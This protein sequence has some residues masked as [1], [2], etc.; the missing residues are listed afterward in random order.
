MLFRNVDRFGQF[1][2][3][4]LNEVAPGS[5][6]RIKTTM[7]AGKLDIPLPGQ[8]N[9]QGFRQIGNRFEVRK[10]TLVN[11]LV[12]LRRPI[13][14]RDCVSLVIEKEFHGTAVDYFEALSSNSWPSQF[15]SWVTICGF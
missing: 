12:D 6:D 1:A 11:S 5:V 4:K 13:V 3:L 10:Q 2:I 8:R 7:N 14:F 15:S 9:T